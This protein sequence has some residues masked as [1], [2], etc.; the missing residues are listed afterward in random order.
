MS[1]D[2]RSMSVYESSVFVDE[3]GERSVFVDE[4]S[5]FVDERPVFVDERSVFVDERSMFVENVS[6]LRDTDRTSDISEVDPPLSYPLRGARC[7][8]RGHDAALGGMMLL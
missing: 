5:M 4:R 1:V 8:S 3:R 6:F 2:E 7:R